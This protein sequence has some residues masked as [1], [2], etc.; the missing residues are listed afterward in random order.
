MLIRHNWISC[1]K[2]DEAIDVFYVY[3]TVSDN[4]SGN[5]DIDDVDERLL[6][7]NIFVSQA[8]VFVD[9]LKPF[10]NVYAPYYRQMSTSVSTG[11]ES[12][13]TEMPEFKIGA[14]DI[15]K[16]FEYYIQNIN[17]DRPFI[18]AGHSQGTMTL[19][20]L[21]KDVF[22]SDTLV[23][24]PLK[25]RLIA[26]YLIGYTVT[27]ADLDSAG[28][29]A[30]RRV[31]DYKV[32]ISYNTLSYEAARGPMLLDGAVCIN[33]L[34]WKVDT[35]FADSSSNMGAVF[36]IDSLGEFQREVDHYCNA[37]LN[38]D[39]GSVMTNIEVDTLDTS[40]YGKGVYHR[41]DYSF[42]YRNLQENVKKRTESFLSNHP[43]YRR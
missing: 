12:L 18:L 35:T 23:L 34:N 37:K 17:T 27:Q 20:E 13:A 21:I 40:A 16:A 43:E 24:D 15:L 9:S 7:Y 1:P 42:W 3:P 14:G 36:Y 6:S 38:L 29:K 19:I 26:A 30:A 8:S 22:S 5:M 10:T 25:E 41:Y 28:L 39:S 4:S 32:V 2:A 31:D 33:P 11:G